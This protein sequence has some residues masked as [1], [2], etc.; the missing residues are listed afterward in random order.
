MGPQA[1]GSPLKRQKLSPMARRRKAARDKAYAMSADRKAKKAHAQ[2]ERRKNPEQA[3]GQDYDHKRQRFVSVRSNRG[4]E[5]IGTR[6]ES[7]ARYNT[8]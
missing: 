7:G 8:D 3:I 2:R 6:A 4:N 1:L 5:G